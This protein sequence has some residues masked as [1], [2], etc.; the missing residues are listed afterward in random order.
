M[1]LRVYTGLPAT[2]KTKAIITEMES[3]KKEGGNNVVLILSSEHE[4]LTRRPNVRP[5]G[6]MGCRDQEK[7]YP[8]DQVI[9]TGTAGQLLR[10]ISPGTMVVFDEAQYFQP[11]LVQDWASASDR[12]VDIVVGTPSQEQLAGLSNLPHE[13]VQITVPCRCGA[14]DAVRAVY[15]D[16]LVYPTHLCENCYKEHMNEHIN[17]LLETVKVAEPFPGELHTYQ[18]FHGIDMGDWG[19]VRKDCT[20]R[21]NIILDAAERSAVV[22]AK[23]QDAV[24]QPSFIDLGCCSG[25]FADGMSS[26]GFRSSGVDVSRNFIDWGTRLAHIKGQAIS[27]HQQDLS[28]FL[29]ENDRHYDIVSTFAT[30]QWVMAQQGYEAGLTCFQEIFDKADSVCVIEMGYTDE[31]IYRDK[32]T[33]RPGE[34]NREWVM[35][36]MQ[37]SGLFNT[38]ELHPSGENGIWRD[39]F[40]GFKAAPTSP[41]VF[42]D[43]PVDGAKQT[44]MTSGYSADGWVGPRMTVG[45]QAESAI[46]RIS[47]EGWRPDESAP[48]TVVLSIGDQ[49]QASEPLSGG[50]FSLSAPVNLATGDYFELVITASES[51]RPQGDDRDLA[52]VLRSLTCS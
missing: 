45:L 21:L 11:Q 9:D 33:D 39:I 43:F 18:P 5:G 38:I 50:L 17:S 13:L 14:G 1:S 24:E 25:F 12:G 28:A 41:R 2:G 26:A 20:A 29:E 3:R 31:E 44:S 49:S 19:L 27:Y 51:F 32:I 52:F 34:I 22:H 30:V 6:L 48:S 16:N 4:E 42:D 15:S 37:D 40:V 23:M 8:I 7:S 46:T 36:L 35:K 10:E 47:L